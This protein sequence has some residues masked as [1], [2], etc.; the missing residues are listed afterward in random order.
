MFITNH[1]FNEITVCC[2][3]SIL[4]TNCGKNIIYF[5]TVLFNL[6]YNIIT[7]MQYARRSNAD[8]CSICNSHL[9]V[10]FKTVSY[11]MTLSKLVSAPAMLSTI[12]L[13]LMSCFRFYLFVKFE[14]CSCK[15]IVSKGAF[16]LL[17][18]NAL[19]ATMV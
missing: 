5:R 14:L 1:S 17:L 2:L 13:N 9:P 8:L 6:Y 10:S 19:F 15:A 3:P 12:A 18:W 11:I 4:L 16:I 7:P